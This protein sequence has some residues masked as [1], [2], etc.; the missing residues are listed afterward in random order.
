MN[1]TIHLQVISSLLAVDATADFVTI[2][3][4]SVIE[5]TD[6]LSEPGF[7]RVR[8]D[9]QELLAFSRDIQERTEQVSSARA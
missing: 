9:G 8:F 4:S 1:P 2:P 3:A 7:H 5:T 6:D